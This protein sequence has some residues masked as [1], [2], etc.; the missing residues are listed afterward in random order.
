MLTAVWSLSMSSAALTAWL[1]PNLGPAAAQTA[2][3]EASQPFDLRW[4]NDGVFLVLASAR[5]L[6]WYQAD[7]LSAEPLYQPFEKMRAFDLDAEGQRV[8][9][10]D[11]LGQVVIVDRSGVVLATWQV[12]APDASQPNAVRALAFAPSGKQIA[13]STDQRVLAVYSLSDQ[14]LEWMTTDG[15]LV[16]ALCFS[17]DSKTLAVGHEQ[18]SLDLRDT[19][20]GKPRRDW[21][22]DV[23]AIESLSDMDYSPS[24]ERLLIGGKGERI[25]ALDV[26]FGERGYDWLAESGAAA[27]VDWSPD[28]RYVAIANDGSGGRPESYSLQV[29]R[30][31]LGGPAVSVM[32]GHSGTVRGLAFSPN[33]ERLASLSDDGTLR[34]WQVS[35][36]ALLGQA[37]YPTSP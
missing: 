30:A 18:L 15:G 14:R 37:S 2:V 21:K 6:W 10:G 8:A 31:E 27:R 3:M 22:L 11:A 32:V 35:S 24:G 20:S 1:V 29:W 36:G 7:D 17:P 13:L 26:I 9:L 34:L 4:T 33:G 19:L 25:L 5:G 12:T 23:L 28:G 16:I